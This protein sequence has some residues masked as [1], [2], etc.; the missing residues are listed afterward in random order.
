MCLGHKRLQNI[1]SV[2]YCLFETKLFPIPL[3]PWVSCVVFFLCINWQ[4]ILFLSC[5]L[6]AMISYEIIVQLFFSDGYKYIGQINNLPKNRTLILVTQPM[7][8]L[9]LIMWSKIVFIDFTSATSEHS[10]W[11][12]LKLVWNPPPCHPIYLSRLGNSINNEKHVIINNP[13]HSLFCEFLIVI[14]Y[15]RLR[16][17]LLKT[18]EHALFI[19][20]NCHVEEGVWFN[21]VLLSLI[22]HFTLKP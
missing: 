6:P 1:S 19:D 12:P 13:Y 7:M 10:K 3:S 8:K 2:V 14:S 20:D 17:T 18:D 9:Q 16:D 11:A 4:M 22:S 5:N 21:T 15:H